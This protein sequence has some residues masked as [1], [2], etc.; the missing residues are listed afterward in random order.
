MPVLLSAEEEA[1]SGSLP[2]SVGVNLAQMQV[3]EHQPD[4][5]SCRSLPLYGLSAANL[6]ESR[7]DSS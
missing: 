5:I 7:S 6:R 3:E 4:L 1:A 2:S